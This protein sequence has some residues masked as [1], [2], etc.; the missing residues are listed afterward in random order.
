MDTIRNIYC[1]GR[2]YVEHVKELKNKIPDQPVIFTKPTHALVKADG[3][4]IQLPK[5]Q[6]EVHYE[7]ELVIKIA[8][9]YTPEKTVDQL[10]DEMAI[11]LDL[12]LRDVQQKLKEKGYPWLLSKGF[13]NSAIISEFI[14]FPGVDQCKKQNFALL[15][16]DEVVQEENITK[17]I[18][19]LETLLHFIGKK[20]GLGKGDIIFTGTP[21]GVGALKHNDQLSLKWSQQE[22]GTC[23]IVFE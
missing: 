18:F 20:L 7:A 14:R 23:V 19:D 2:N 13:R 12:T 4:T 6:G 8:E 16:N 21:S 9:D 3:A 1:V 22:L 10:V 11:G 5:H 15:I 17:M